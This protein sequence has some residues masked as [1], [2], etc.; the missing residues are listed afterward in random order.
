MS[1]IQHIFFRKGLPIFLS[2]HG[3]RY[4]TWI[5][6]CPFVRFFVPKHSHLNW[7]LRS[8]TIPNIPKSSLLG[9]WIIPMKLKIFL[10]L[11]IQERL[12][13]DCVLK[14]KKWRDPHCHI[15][16]GLETVDHILFRCLPARFTW[17]CSKE[18]LGWE[19]VPMGLNDPFHNWVFLGC[20]DSHRLA[21][22]F[23]LLPRLAGR[24]GALVFL[25]SCVR[26]CSW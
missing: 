8:S 24:L 21:V 10:W 17:A 15:C 14:Q 2:A 23:L 22:L 4:T 1:S 3:H 12:Q 25:F 20:F 5:C 11:T 19:R 6:V 13:T 16:G 7:C 9:T 18:I 26:H